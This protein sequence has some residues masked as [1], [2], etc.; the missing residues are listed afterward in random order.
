MR[1]VCG[2]GRGG[3]GGAAC[4]GYIDVLLVEGP[5]GVLAEDALELLLVGEQLIELP[6]G[7][8]VELLLVVE[9]AVELPLVVEELIELLVGLFVELPL[10]LIENVVVVVVGI[11]VVTVTF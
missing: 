6:V 1:L 5:L 10:G 4:E 2:T 11:T 8:V 3:G 7:L 9:D